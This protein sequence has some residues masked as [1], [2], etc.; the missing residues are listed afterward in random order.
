[1]IRSGH[2]SDSKKGGACIY[3]EEHVSLIK[4]DDICTVDKCLVTEIRSQNEKRFLTCLYHSPSQ[5][6]DENIKPKL[7]HK[8]WY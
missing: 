5:S 6:H 7:L 2:L 1:M 8:V 4:W 3:Y